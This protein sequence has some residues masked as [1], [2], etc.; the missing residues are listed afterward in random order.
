MSWVSVDC[1]IR[2]PSGRSALVWSEEELPQ[3]PF[4][5]L[6]WLRYVASQ[7]YCIHTIITVFTQCQLKVEFTTKSFFY[8]V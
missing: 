5:S 2:Y 4:E 6:G 3:G 8:N 7:D 1:S